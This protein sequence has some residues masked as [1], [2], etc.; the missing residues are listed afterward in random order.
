MINFSK[1]FIHKFSQILLRNY[2][3]NS[4]ESKNEDMVKKSKND[5]RS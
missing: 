3:T 2:I 1:E 5:L 4:K